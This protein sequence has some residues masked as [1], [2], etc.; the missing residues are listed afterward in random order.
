M[1]EESCVNT[2]NQA[3][4]GCTNAVPA[5]YPEMIGTCGA[6]QFTTELDIRQHASREAICFND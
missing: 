4:F 3:L 6:K 2:Y 1:I 5:S